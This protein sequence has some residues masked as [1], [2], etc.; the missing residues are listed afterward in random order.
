MEII[1]YHFKLIP[2]PEI[3]QKAKPSRLLHSA[4]TLAFADLDITPVP[5]SVLPYIS[6][7]REAPDRLLLGLGI[8]SKL[9]LNGL[10]MVELFALPEITQPLG[11]TNFSF[12]PRGKSVVLVSP[13]D[14]YQDS[15]YK[16]LMGLEKELLNL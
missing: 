14:L 5:G 2:S 13:F 6:S 10:Y 9:D 3:L 4:P 8:E 11:G 15:V 12:T 16:K 7:S 1:R